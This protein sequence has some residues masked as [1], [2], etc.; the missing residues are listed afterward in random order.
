MK[1]LSA[2]IGIRP[3]IGVLLALVFATGIP[4]QENAPIV[5]DVELVVFRNL[6]T[7]STP[8]DW[9]LE[10]RLSP[11]P[12]ALPA[13]AADEEVSQIVSADS[14]GG[15]PIEGRPALPREKFKLGGIAASLQRSR[16]YRTIAHFGWSQVGSP[17]NGAVSMPLDGLLPAGSLKGSAAL[18]R[19]RYLHLTLDLDYQPDGTGQH[20][21]IRQTRRMRS[22][23]RHYI[24]HPQFGVVALITP[25]TAATAR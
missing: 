17:L 7:S 22:N 24:D 25:Q 8:E 9:A 6:D 19:G 1:R 15:M 20:Y 13:A 14:L 12:G 10:D 21:Y 2:A 11:G 3:A 23:E 18:A 4:A 5:Y 16:T